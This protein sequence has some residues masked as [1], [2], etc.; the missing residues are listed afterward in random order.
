MVVDWP[1]QCFGESRHAPALWPDRCHI[2][3]LHLI[4]RWVDS[5]AVDQDMSMGYVL[6]SD[7][8]SAGQ[9]GAHLHRI[10]V[11]LKKLHQDI[12][13]GN[14]GNP[15]RPADSFLQVVA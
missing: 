1:L 7:V 12:T 2:S 8:N 4:S 5:L 10:Q 11:G 14:I 6:T 15:L 13:A 9:P 3:Y